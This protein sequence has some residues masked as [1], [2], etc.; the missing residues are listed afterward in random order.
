MLTLAA[1]DIAQ[2]WAEYPNRAP[3]S[4]IEG[5]ERLRQALR[6]PPLATIGV[7]GTNGKTSTATYL[8]RMLSASGL[9]TGL[10]VSP[11]LDDWTERVRVDDEPCDPQELVEAL[12]SV[13]ELAISMDEELAELRFFDVLTLAAE[14]L[15]GRAGASVA[16]FEAGIGGRLDAVCALRPPLVLL[17]GIAVDHADV[18]GSEPAGILREKLLLAPPGGYV[19][20]AP[21]G[22]EL[23]EVAEDLAAGAGIDLAWLG[24]EDSPQLSLDSDLPGYLRSAFA[25]AA[26]GKRLAEERLGPFSGTANGGAP[27]AIDL[28]IP[29]RLERGERNGVPYVFDVAH[30]EAAWLNLAAEL[31]EFPFDAPQ[32]GSVTALVSVSPG[33]RQEGLAAALRRLP[34][35]E[36]A[37]VTRHTP[38]PAADPDAVATELRRAGVEARVVDDVAVAC[39]LAFEQARRSGGGVLALGSTHLVSDLRRLL[40]QE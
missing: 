1:G 27:P 18:L 22:P 40:H 3:R 12:R 4:S 6:P 35:L 8:A 14:L 31:G 15:L 16:V 37:I 20:S 19:L 36:E 30:N 13:H 28:R 23:E 11:H 39:R 2:I 7:V 38:L 32:P 9:R 21:L 34:G 33:K 25:L 5:V 10:Y 29:G 26:E 17:T 24:S